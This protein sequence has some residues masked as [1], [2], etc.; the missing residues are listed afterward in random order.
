MYIYIGSRHKM[1]YIETEAKF[2]LFFQASLTTLVAGLSIYKLAGEPDNMTPFYW[3]MLLMLLA[4]WMPS[5]VKGK[6]NERD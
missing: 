4:W 2:R 6:Y 3:E 5:P 1:T